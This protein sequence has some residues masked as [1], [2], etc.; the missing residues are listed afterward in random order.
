[1]INV[2]FL[3]PDT[4]DRLVWKTHDDTFK[5]FSLGA[6]WESIRPRGDVVDWFDLVW[7]SHRIPRHTINLWLV[8]K[9]KLKTQDNLRQWDVSTDTNLNL[10]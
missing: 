5:D 9:R 7:F 10:F 4:L 3:Y 2:P 1:M 8:V 6:V